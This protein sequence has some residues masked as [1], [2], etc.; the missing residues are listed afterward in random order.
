MSSALAAYSFA[1]GTGVT[2]D[3]NDHF[4]VGKYNALEQL[5]VAFAVGNGTGNASRSDA[6]QVN[7]NGT[8]N[9][10]S[11]LTVGGTVVASGTDLVQE[12]SNLQA[13]N[14][15]MAAQIAEL[16]AAIELLQ[17]GLNGPNND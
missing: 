8:A 6:F 13:A 4:A 12:I 5:N 16:Q 11:T 15:A 7:F 1:H 14:A 3:H 10:S 2:T 9:L 17:Q